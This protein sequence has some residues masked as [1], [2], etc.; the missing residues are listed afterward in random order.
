[1]AF[2]AGNWFVSV[3][4]QDEQGNKTVQTYDMDAASA[5][6]AATAATA[7]TTAYAAITSADIVAYSVGQRYAEDSPT[8][9]A[10]SHVEMKASV[11]VALSTPPKRGNLAIASPIAALFVN[12]GVGPSGNTV[13]VANAALTTFTNLFKSTATSP[14]YLSDGET[15]TNMLSGRRV[16]RNR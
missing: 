16:F 13:D 15:L 1:M 9:P 5:A 4:L 3:T 8:F 6:A 2:V 7:F 11:T 12:A 14:L 10:G